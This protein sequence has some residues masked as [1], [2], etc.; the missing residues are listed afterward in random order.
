MTL[1]DPQIFLYQKIKGCTYASGNYSVNF[2]EYPTTLLGTTVEAFGRDLSTRQKY[3]TIIVMNVLVYALN[4]FDF[5]LTIYNSLK[6]GGLLLFHDR[7]F[8]DM[9]HSSTCKFAGFYTH[10]IQCSK[11]LL[12]HFLDS[13][14][15]R[16]FYSTNQ[17][18][19]MKMRNLHWCH[20]RDDERGYFVALRKGSQHIDYVNPNM[21]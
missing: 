1:V 7:W 12:D 20:G 15:Q 16:E 14:P 17:T 8:S 3:D 19:G 13:F 10:I 21:I 6:P 18:H 4:A 5:L 11:G 2:K 9:V